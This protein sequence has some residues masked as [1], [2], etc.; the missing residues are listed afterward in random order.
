MSFALSVHCCATGMPLRAASKPR[1][2]HL[3]GKSN[4]YQGQDFFLPGSGRCHFKPESVPSLLRSWQFCRYSRL[5]S[6]VSAKAS[7][8]SVSAVWLI[9]LDTWPSS[10]SASRT[11]V[12]QSKCAILPRCAA[13]YAPVV[14]ILVCVPASSRDRFATA[15]ARTWAACLLLKV[16]VS[17]WRFPLW[18]PQYCRFPVTHMPQ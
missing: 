14:R 3:S 13:R 8:A 10:R 11:I 4:P 2:R 1:L 15:Y 16:M 7:V 12:T 9:V 5:C 6:T 17:R 18:F